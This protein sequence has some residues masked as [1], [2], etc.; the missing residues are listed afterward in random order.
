MKIPVHISLSSNKRRAALEGSKRREGAISRG[1]RP[2]P[3]AASFLHPISLI[4]SITWSLH[5]GRH[6]TIPHHTMESTFG[7]LH[8]AGAARGA[9]RQC[10]QRE[11]Y[12]KEK[13]HMWKYNNTTILHGEIQQ[14]RIQHRGTPYHMGNTK[15]R[16]TP[17]RNITWGNTTRRNTTQ[18]NTT[19]KDSTRFT[20][21][22]PHG[23]A[24]VV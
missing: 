9:T 3:G 12:H 1:A 20:G 19:E 11:N 18:G 21:A 13:Y 7:A 17:R 10:T 5:L 6:T 4:T 16:D 2:N 23:D 8:T 24:E 15:Q 22:L 14:G